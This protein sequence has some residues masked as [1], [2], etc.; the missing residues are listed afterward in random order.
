MESHV[1]LEDLL[2]LLDKG[3]TLFVLA[4]AV[5]AFLTRRVVPA[6]V[7]RELEAREAEWKRIA[8]SGTHV[9]QRVVTLAEQTIPHDP[10][11]GGGSGGGG[12][13]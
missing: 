11:A 6:W 3:G 10:G 12:G 2:Q 4:G 7:Y 9:A 13:A 8:L 1:T 5:W